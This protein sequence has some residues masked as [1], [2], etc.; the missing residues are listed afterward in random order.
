MKKS[1]IKPGVVYAYQR[2]GRHPVDPREPIVFLGMSEYGQGHVIGEL[3][4]DARGHGCRAFMRPAPS[5]HVQ[6]GTVHNDGSI[7]YPAV[8]LDHEA[9]LVTTER[10]DSL[11][12]VTPQDF[13]VAVSARGLGS[14]RLLLVV[15]SMA[16]V[17]GPWED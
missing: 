12:S 8:L 2:F 5:R 1:D 4:Q 11:L 15:T 10:L 14:G 6:A 13:R 9:P 17:V 7:G 3:W 16:R